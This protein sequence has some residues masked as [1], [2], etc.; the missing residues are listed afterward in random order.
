MSLLSDYGH[1]VMLVGEDGCG[2]TSLVSDR[3]RTVCSGEV[4]EVLALVI[5]TNRY[6]APALKQSNFNPSIAK[7]TFVQ[8]TRKQRFFKT[9]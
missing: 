8:S 3:I 5:N 1:P 2:K 4:A 9:F 7:A 6:A